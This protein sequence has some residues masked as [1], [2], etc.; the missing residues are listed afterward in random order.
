[1]LLVV[2]GSTNALALPSLDVRKINLSGLLL[3]QY[4]ALKGRAFGRR[5]SRRNIAAAK[6]NGKLPSVKL[7]F[8]CIKC[9]KEFDVPLLAQLDRQLSLRLRHLAPEFLQVI[10]QPLI[11]RLFVQ[12]E[13]KP[14]IRRRQ[15]TGRT[16]AA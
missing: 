2:A 5:G 14:A 9:I 6:Q 7:R 16:R 1:V 12:S 15:I 3:R 11:L 13:G 10:L 8:L 4:P